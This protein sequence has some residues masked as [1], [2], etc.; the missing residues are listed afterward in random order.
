MNE[1]NIKNKRKAAK[2]LIKIIPKKSDKSICEK[3]RKLFFI[4]EFFTQINHNYFEIDIKE[5]NNYHLWDYSNRYIYNIIRK[6]IEKHDDINSLAESLEENEEST[7]EKLKEFIEFSKD[8]KILLNQNNDF[9]E[10]N[11]LLNEKDWGKGSEKLKEIALYLD[12]DVKEK[13]SHKSMG[14]PCK[15]DMLYKDICDE[16]DEIM[17]SKFKE[18]SNHQDENFR[19][20][21]KNLSE[22]FDKIGKKKAEKYFRSTF[23]IKEKIAYNVIYDEKT[24]KSLFQLDKA[25]GIN[26]LSELSKNPKIQDFVKKLLKNNE[27]V[28]NVIEMEKKFENQA[29]NSKIKEN[30]ENDDKKINQYLKFEEKYGKD[31]ISKLL[32]ISDNEKIVSC[33]INDEEL[34]NNFSKYNIDSFKIFK[35]RTFR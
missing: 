1:K 24:H 14:N 15:R 18:I 2:Y 9:C 7:I 12:Y 6:I 21:A 22:Y 28:E 29:N 3:Q 25:F 20:A 23:A 26:N 32:N 10:I 17:S 31:A 16:I 13:L 30:F 19:S 34:F 27:L 33:L 5:S 11:E 8:G 35:R 4:Y